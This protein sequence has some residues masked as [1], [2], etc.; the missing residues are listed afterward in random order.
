MLFGQIVIEDQ[1]IAPVIDRGRTM[2]SHDLAAKCLAA[3]AVTRRHHHNGM[4]RFGRGSYVRQ[5]LIA[6]QI[7]CKYTQFA[8]GTVY[9][10][11]GVSA[12]DS[13]VLKLRSTPAGNT[14]IAQRKEEPMIARQQLVAHEYIA[15]YIIY[16][17]R[18][19]TMPTVITGTLE[20]VVQRRHASVKPQSDIIFTAAHGHLQSGKQV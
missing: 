12:M 17:W 15:H 8:I 3:A 13:K 2:C 7:A 16:E 1:Q 10:V 19:D 11:R 14:R 5:Y 6:R 18:M 9:T 20:P 4:P